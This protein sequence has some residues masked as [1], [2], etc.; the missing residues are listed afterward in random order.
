MTCNIAQRSRKIKRPSTKYTVTPWIIHIVQIVPI[1]NKSWLVVIYDN[2]GLG[3]A[4]FLVFLII[5]LHCHRVLF[6]W[7]G[8]TLLFYPIFDHLLTLIAF[9]KIYLYCFWN[10]YYM[11]EA[12]EMVKMEYL[13][14]KRYL[15]RL[16]NGFVLILALV[17]VRIGFGFFWWYWIVLD[18]LV[19]LVLHMTNDNSG[20]SL[21]TWWSSHGEWHWGGLWPR[22]G[23]GECP[24]LLYASLSRW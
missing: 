12:F 13:L 23:A 8:F 10:S 7:L 4:V 22:D 9:T 11:N 19:R 1:K 20:W 24:L 6:N 3:D 17:W 5:V 14:W 21:F 18:G 16:K 2:C 15:I